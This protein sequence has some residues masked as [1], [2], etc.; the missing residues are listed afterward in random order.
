MSP[1]FVGIMPSIEMVICAAVGGRE[2]IFGAVYGTLVVNFGKTF[3]SEE[4]PELWLF[5]IG[6]L[7]I[8]VVLVFPNGLAGLKLRDLAQLPRRL[9]RSSRTGSPLAAGLLAGGGGPGSAP[10]VAEESGT[11]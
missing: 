2:S 7:F 3:F 11:P 5:L 4:F 1:S 9:R 10:A 8:A 6:T